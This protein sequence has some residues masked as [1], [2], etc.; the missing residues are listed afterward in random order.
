MKKRIVVITDCTDV[1]YNELCGHYAGLL[2][3]NDTVE[4]EP[5]VSVK[6]FS[7]INGAFILRLIV[8]A[9]PAG[10]VISVILN[11]SQIRPERIACKLKNKDVTIVTANTGVLNLVE[12]EYDIADC[13][14]IEDPGFFVFGGKYVHTPAVAKLANGASLQDLGKNF[15]LS[16]LRSLDLADRVVH[17]DNFGLL[18]IT[19]KLDAPSVGNMYEVQ[20]GKQTIT[21][22]YDIRMMSNNDGEWIVYPGSSFDLLEIGKVRENGAKELDAHEGDLVSFKKIPPQA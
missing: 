19:N 2:N 12:Q 5:V 9:Y 10:T 16:K 22:K 8:D 14:E 18:K 4:L 7:I 3:G 11:P 15:D 20:I 1:A 6:P 17:V 13:V 21:A